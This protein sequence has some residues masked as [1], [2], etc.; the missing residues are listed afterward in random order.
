MNK[1]IIQDLQD[2]INNAFEKE[3]SIGLDSLLWSIDSRHR[4]ILMVNEINL[5]LK[6]FGSYEIDRTED[7]V[8]ISLSRKPERDEITKSDIDIAHKRYIKVITS[9]L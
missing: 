7:N 5:A 3:E 4:V 6:N 8:F 1:S 9:A 2:M